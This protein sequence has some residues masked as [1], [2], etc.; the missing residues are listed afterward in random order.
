MCSLSETLKTMQETGL[1]YRNDNFYGSGVRDIEDIVYF[2]IEELG[3]TDIIYTMSKLY[4]LDWEKYVEEEDG[5]YFVPED[6]LHEIQNNILSYLEKHFG[7]SHTNLCGIWLTTEE[8]VKKR[9]CSNSEEEIMEISIGK[10]WLPISDLGFD[11]TLFV[12]K[13][14][15]LDI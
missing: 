13:K 3:N 4:K 14:G 15:E 1:G 11:G 8:A 5:D 9:Y 10:T 6:Y 12:Y 2:E 7:E